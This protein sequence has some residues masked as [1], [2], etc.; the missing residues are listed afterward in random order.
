MR[1]RRRKRGRNGRRGK[2]KH[3][4]KGNCKG[5]HELTVMC[6]SLGGPPRSRS[7]IPPPPPPPPIEDELPAPV[8][9]PYIAKK[10]VLRHAS[11]EIFFWSHQLK[12]NHG[13]SFHVSR[14]TF[15]S[16]NPTQ[17]MQNFTFPV[18]FPH[19]LSVLH[20]LLS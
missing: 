10:V 4:K 7:P 9:G 20:R 19:N 13:R 1:R 2:V 11:H 5:W 14:I 17:Q 12:R 8:L 6:R 15:R 16:S 18:H 3:K